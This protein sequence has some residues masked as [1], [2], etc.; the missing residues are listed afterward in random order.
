MLKFVQPRLLKPGKRQVPFHPIKA[1][2]F[3][4]MPQTPFEYRDAT[5]L[6]PAK[7]S[8]RLQFRLEMRRVLVSTPSVYRDPICT[9]RSESLFD[10]GVLGGL[11]A[12]HSRITMSF[13]GYCRGGGGSG[14]A[15]GYSLLTVQRP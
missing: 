1:V 11:M 7:P 8:L 3:Q 12:T 2:V 5:I 10:C 6:R 9:T 15:G 4:A 14:G 13:G